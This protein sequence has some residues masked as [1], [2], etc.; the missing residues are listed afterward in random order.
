MGSL[1]IEASPSA[2]F[3]SLLAVAFAD[4]CVGAGRRPCEARLRRDAGM[5]EIYAEAV[6]QH[7]TSS[8]RHGR[9]MLRMDGRDPRKAGLERGR[10]QCARRYEA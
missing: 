6:R 1:R 5:T 9:A 4:P 10:A 8:R 2:W 7:S 3:R